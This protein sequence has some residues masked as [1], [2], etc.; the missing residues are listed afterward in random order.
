MN[1]SK[2]CISNKSSLFFSP[3]VK[4]SF[5]NVSEVLVCPLSNLSFTQIAGP[6]LYI[7]NDFVKLLT[8]LLLFT[9]NLL[10]KVNI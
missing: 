2:L 3:S 8:L 5:L 6:S 4:S 1:S 9:N 7:N 10:H